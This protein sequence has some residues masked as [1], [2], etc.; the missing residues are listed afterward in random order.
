[1]SEQEFYKEE[2]E[3]QVQL[4]IKSI[5]ELY[6]PED[7][8]RLYGDEPTIGNNTFEFVTDVEQFITENTTKYMKTKTKATEQINEF[9]LKHPWPNG[10]S[11][12]DPLNLSGIPKSYI[13]SDQ[14]LGISPNGKGWLHEV[15]LNCIKPYINKE[16]TALEIGPGEGGWTKCMLDAKSIYTLD[17]IPPSEFWK[18]VNH[19][20]N[21]KYIVVEDFLCNDLPENYFNYVFSMGTLCHIPFDGVEAYAK[22]MFDKLKPGANCFWMIADEKK[23]S[24][25]VKKDVKLPRE[26]TPNKI[27]C[28]YE[29]G[30]TETRKM[31]ERIGYEIVCEDLN[32]IPRDPLIHFKK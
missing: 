4:A 17:I 10:Y 23:F 16:T 8:E 3:K 25:A 11:E 7:Y 19:S 18:T 12:G 29:H 14:H 2:Y 6:Y 24:S 27:G 30:I 13:S 1:M 26:Y 15:Y 20:N 28:F 5:V 22:N 9:K 21:I 32:L 31:L